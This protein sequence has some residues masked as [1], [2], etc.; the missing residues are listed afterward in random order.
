MDFAFA[1]TLLLG[2]VSKVSPVAASEAVGENKKDT[3]PDRG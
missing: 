1:K 3:N 2:K